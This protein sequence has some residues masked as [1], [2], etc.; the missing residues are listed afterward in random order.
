M[1]LSSIRRALTLLAL[2][3]TVAAGARAAPPDHAIAMHGEPALPEDFAHLPYVDP[4]APKGGRLNLAY[5][6]AFDSLN[7]YNIKALS[8]AQG[9]IGNVYQSLMVRSWDEP[10][11]LYGLIARSI[12]TDD[13]RDRVV[14]HL[15]PRAHFSDGGRITADDVIFTF[16][17]LEEKGRPQQRAAYSL[18]KSIDAPD[19]ETVRYD[20]TGA[21][22][23]ELPLTLALM[24][25]LSRAHTDAAHFED[26][27]LALPVASGPYRVVEVQPGQRLVL[28]RDPD[29]WA[30]DL[31]ISRGLYNFDEIR[32]DYYRD[33]A[34]MFEAFKA[35]LYDF[36]IEDDATRWLD[37]YD[38]PALRDGRIVKQAF[39][40]GLPKGISGFAF[41]TRREIFADP[42]VREA[43]ST[44]FDF[45]WIDANL[46][47][48]AYKRSRSFFDDSQLSSAGRPATAKE[49]AL[50]APF[51]G[52]VRKDILEGEWAPPVSDG[53]GRDRSLARRAF[54]ELK[55]AGYTLSD[56]AMRDARGR[57]LAFEILIK[58]RQEERLAV[59]YSQSLARI[60]V[61]ATVR[62]VDEVQYQ[63]RRDK[64]DFDMTIGSW[65]ASPSP[66][67]EQRNRWGTRSADLEGSYN[68]TGAK[69][70]AIDAMISAMLS[71]REMDDFVAATRALDRLLL[72]GFYIVP[73]Y[74]APD[75]WIAYTARLG[76]PERTPLFGPTFEDWWSRTP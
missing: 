69:S 4:D 35:G 2:A 3:V 15:D 64:F 48:G 40:I 52:A 45:E 21:N 70:P 1:T 9:L 12:E 31:P 62:L 17:L 75:E 49:R 51:P 18:V 46:Y 50:L 22:D 14:F 74:Y 41:N 23:R 68:L 38:F 67:A 28:Q 72:S 60:G 8:T 6:G 61:A 24:P 59:A 33:A 7:P 54:D 53:S 30:R 26:Q 58:T 47:S 32:I 20:L 19:D 76:R 37:G 11:T 16:R 27:T 43:L 57:R 10:F 73:L 71:A 13:A 55:D 63:R 5:L 42:R 56:G 25:V 66:G 44:V 39:P 65:A 34:A 29:Y 36:R